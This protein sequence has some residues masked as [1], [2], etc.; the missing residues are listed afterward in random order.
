MIAI[1][2]YDNNHNNNNNNIIYLDNRDITSEFSNL[3]TNANY[4]SIFHNF[5]NQV[6]TSTIEMYNIISNDAYGEEDDDDDF[7]HRRRLLLNVSETDNLTLISNI[8]NVLQNSLYVSELS[9]IS[10]KDVRKM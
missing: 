5:V 9:V 1:T 2:Q 4:L 8:I 3:V 6:L 7:Q 10:L